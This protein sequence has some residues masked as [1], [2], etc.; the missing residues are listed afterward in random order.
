MRSARNRFLNHARDFSIA[1]FL[2]RCRTGL[3]VLRSLADRRPHDHNRRERPICDV[4]S[5]YALGY[6]ACWINRR[7]IG[8]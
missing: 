3:T 7:E 8:R 5:A 6:A 4:H 1:R 2:L